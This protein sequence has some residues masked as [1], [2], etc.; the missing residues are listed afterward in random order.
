MS[1]YGCQGDPAAA[2]AAAAAVDSR[3]AQYFIV[4]PRTSA[5]PARALL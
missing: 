2:A 3:P 5:K 1:L 4:N